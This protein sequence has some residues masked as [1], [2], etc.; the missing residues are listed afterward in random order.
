[1]GKG[2]TVSPLQTVIDRTKEADARERK[3]D[4]KAIIT[5]SALGNEKAVDEIADKFESEDKLSE[6]LKGMEL[7][8]TVDY[9][10]DDPSE[11][12][13]DENEDEDEGSESVEEMLIY[14]EVTA[15]ERYMTE[16][17]EEQRPRSR[18][19]ITTCRYCGEIYRFR[20]EEPQPPT[21]GK[22]QC[23]MKLEESS[24]KKAVAI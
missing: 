24:K 13:D 10:V 9:V 19:F 20:S 18:W 8:D 5:N 2:R 14:S 21:C 23:I 7:E 1:M 17:T 16:V 12:E 6:M 22:P 15:M 4:M 3:V 11:D